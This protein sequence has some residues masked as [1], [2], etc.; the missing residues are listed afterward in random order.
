MAW[1]NRL[2]QHR[3]RRVIPRRRTD[4]RFYSSW[5]VP[6]GAI[7]LFGARGARAGVMLRRVDG[8]ANLTHLV[9]EA[10]SRHSTDSGYLTE[11]AMW[12]GRYGAVAGVPARSTPDPDLSAALPAR[13]FAG[14]VLAQPPGDHLDRG[15]RRG[16]CAGHGRR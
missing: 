12:S 16:C 5:P 14:P 10:A 8:L 11:L 1:R 3:F 4:P 2:W 13:S 15:Q 6:Q 7:A 9:A